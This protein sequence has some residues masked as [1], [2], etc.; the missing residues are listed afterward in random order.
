MKWTYIV[1]PRI[2]A[3]AFNTFEPAERSYL[4]LL[5]VAVDMLLTS[6]RFQ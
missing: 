3:L 4:L 6:Y 2:K 1:F 5:A